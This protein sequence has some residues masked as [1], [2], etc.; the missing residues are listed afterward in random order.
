MMTFTRC[1][2][3]IGDPR[4]PSET[5]GDNGLRVRARAGGIALARTADRRLH[6]QAAMRPRQALPLAESSGRY[7]FASSI[8]PLAYRVQSA[9]SPYW[10]VS[11]GTP[12]LA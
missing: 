10:M 12:V 11:I 9:R 7:S 1:T 6:S 4:R 5:I 8:I 2:G 3:T